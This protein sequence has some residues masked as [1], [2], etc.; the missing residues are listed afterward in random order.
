VVGAG[1]T[2]AAVYDG[3]A[4]VGFAVL[5]AAERVS[6]PPVLVTNTTGSVF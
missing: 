5:G 1:V 6:T 4:V 3:I 2:T